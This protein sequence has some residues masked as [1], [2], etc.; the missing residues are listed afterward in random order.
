MMGWGGGSLGRCGSINDNGN[1]DNNEE[2][3]PRTILA[4]KFADCLREIVKRK[5]DKW[6][7]GELLTKLGV[8]G[9]LV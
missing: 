6:G 7:K 3:T 1:K 5:M 2:P 9:A 4:V 8:S